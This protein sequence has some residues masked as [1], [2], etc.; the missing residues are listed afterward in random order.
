MC[1]TSYRKAMLLLSRCHL[2]HCI[3]AGI[4]TKTT[5]TTTTTKPTTAATTTTPQQSY[6]YDHTVAGCFSLFPATLC[7]SGQH[8]SNIQL[9]GDIGYSHMNYPS[10]TSGYSCQMEALLGR[11]PF[12]FSDTQLTWNLQCTNKY[13]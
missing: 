6:R 8:T 12:S 11:D 13:D 10:N 9:K 5:T 4:T 7:H 2:F 3:H 1:L